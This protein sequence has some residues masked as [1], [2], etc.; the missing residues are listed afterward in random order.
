[1]P[2]VSTELPADEHGGLHRQSAAPLA[3]PPDEDVKDLSSAME[4]QLH[5]SPNSESVAVSQQ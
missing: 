1:M 4:K 2:T 3:S 5:V